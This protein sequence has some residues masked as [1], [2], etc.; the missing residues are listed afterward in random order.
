[1]L[2]ARAAHAVVSTQTAIYAL[3]GTGKS[4]PVVDV[5]RFDGSAWAVETLLPGKGLNAPAAVVLN[6]RIYLIGGFS[7]L[8][9]MPTDGVEV[10]DPATKTWSEAAPLPEP[11][12]GHA[13]VVLDGKIYAIGGRSGFEDFGDVYVYNP[14]TDSWSTGPS[15]APRGTAGAVVYCDAITIFGGEAQAEGLTL[16][17]V[18][19]LDADKG[20]WN[21]ATPMP[22]ARNFARAVLF[23][24]SVYVV[25][26]SPI[27][28]SSHSS[29]GSAVVERF[30]VDCSK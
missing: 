21:P 23:Q 20:V 12:G 15:I 11:R 16:N 5:E 7:T 27:A 30:R 28:G 10:Y 6:D 9:N 4:G 18:E 2:N 29:Q 3:A 8:T 17:I 13:A 26:G 25:G 19:W 1:M 14:A 24:D 22:T